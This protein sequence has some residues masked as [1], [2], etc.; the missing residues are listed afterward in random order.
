[1]T[2]KRGL[3]I[4]GLAALAVGLGGCITLFPTAAPVQFYGFGGVFPAPPP[5]EPVGAPVNIELGHTDFE[6][7]AAGD[8]ILTVN[9]QEDAYIAGS[10]WISPATVLFQE[11]EARAFAADGHVRL[12]RPGQM[13]NAKAMLQLDVPTFE[14]RYPGSLKAAPMVVVEVNARLIGLPDGHVIAE[15]AITSAKPVGDNRVGDIVRGFD[16]A[17]VET[18]G[19]LFAWTDQTIA[20]LPAG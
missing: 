13:A 10:R 9:N 2:L 3:T 8:R 4:A 15:R 7:A 17:V 19:Q 12:V 14:V 1:M 6:R 16:A 5:A 11:A 18:L 20:S